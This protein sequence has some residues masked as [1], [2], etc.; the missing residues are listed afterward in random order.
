MA[1]V[2]VSACDD[3]AVTSAPDAQFEVTSTDG[4]TTRAC[5][6][7]AVLVTDVR[8]QIGTGTVA[9]VLLGSNQVNAS[10]IKNGATK[11]Q[12]YINGSTKPV[13]FNQG[14]LVSFVEHFGYHRL[15]L[16]L[17][18][19]GT[20][21]I[22]TSPGPPPPVLRAA[23]L[24]DVNSDG[25]ADA[26]FFFPVRDLVKG[27]LVEGAYSIGIEATGAGITGSIA[28]STTGLATDSI[29]ISPPVPPRGVTK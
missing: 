25:S 7:P 2:V 11:V 21:T 22:G 14:S 9:V 6:D 23:M 1:L 15:N 28:G 27:G 26:I 13:T 5:L 29:G 3:A 4:C 8:G 16:N 24:Q 18:S 12:L 19:M 17:S 20:D 10:A